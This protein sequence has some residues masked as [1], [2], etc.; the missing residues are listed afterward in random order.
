MTTKQ[1][2]TTTWI[3]IS[4]GGFIGEAVTHHEIEITNATS[5]PTGTQPCHTIKGF[6]SYQFPAP[7]SGSWYARV[8][9]GNSHLV[10]TEV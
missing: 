10:Y 4:S 8:A 1:A 9:S 7:L 2:L 6:D 3:E 5:T